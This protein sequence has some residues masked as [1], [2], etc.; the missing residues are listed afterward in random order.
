MAEKIVVQCGSCGS[1]FDVSGY[2]QGIAFKC[3]KCGG[4]VEYRPGLPP[5]K[6]PEDAERKGGVPATV[7]E[8][9]EIGEGSQTAETVMELSAGDGGEEE[10][11]EIGDSGEEEK[12][13]T[14]SRYTAMEAFKRSREGE[15]VKGVKKFGDFHVIQELGRGAMG[16]VYE[17][18]Q[19]PL[20]RRV[21]LKVMLPSFT[22]SPEAVERFLRESKSTAKLKHPNIVPVYGMGEQDGTYF[23][24]MGFIE[25][26]SLK[27]ALK[28]DVMP[29]KERAAILRDA[30]RALHYAHEQGV[31]HRD[32]KPANIMIDKDKKVL[33]ADFGIAKSEEQST[34]TASGQVL[35][36]PMYM[37]P[38]QAEGGS[39]HVDGR[40]DIYSLGATLY[41]SIT[42][43]RPY[44]G[45]DVRS[46][47]RNVIETEPVSPRKIDPKIPRDLE[48]VCLKA[49]E[50]P[51]NK[52]YETAGDM[53]ED[54]DHFI[55]GEPIKAKPIGPLARLGRKMRKNKLTTALILLV[56][57]LLAGGAGVTGYRILEKQKAARERQDRIEKG[58]KEAAAIFEKGRENPDK[59]LE[60]K[61]AY[62]RV[63]AIDTGNTAAKE[64]TEKCDLMIKDLNRLK[65]EA[66]VRQALREASAAFEKE[67]YEEAKKI[68]QQILLF[69]E[70]NDAAQVGIEKCD[71]QI[72]HLM[73]EKEKYAK[74]QK[75]KALAKAGEAA[76]REGAG[77]I[78]TAGGHFEEGEEK[79]GRMALKEALALLDGAAGKF[80]EAL[81]LY[82]GYRTA[83]H[84]RVGAN[85]AR[86][87]GAVLVKAYARAVGFLL[88]AKEA[89]A[90]EFF[91]ERWNAL[92]RKAVGT[93]TLTLRSN[94]A[95]AEVTVAV[96]E[97]DPAARKKPESLGTTPIEGRDMAMGN[98][99]LRLEKAGFEPVIYPLMVERN[100]AV[101]AEVRLLAK[102]AIP[103]GMVYVPGGVFRRG[104]AYAGFEKIPVKGFFM[105]VREVSHEEYFEFMQTIPDQ[106]ERMLRLPRKV[107]RDKTF[108]WWRLKT[109]KNFQK[110]KGRKLPCWGI[111]R[112]NAQAYAAW[113]GKRLPTVTEWEKAARGVD[114]RQWPWGNVFLE[115]RC[116]FFGRRPKLMVEPVDAYEQWRSPYGCVNMAGNVAEWTSTNGPQ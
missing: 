16:V 60:A 82:P 110:Q 1:S 56:M 35:G 4:R 79:A 83:R 103:E 114:G 24:A 23:Y 111:S 11:S 86:A 68:Y 10:E 48:T 95:G 52:R 49:M 108:V 94:P 39:S 98:Y 84:G 7:I 67:A 54:L 65:N 91:P 53:G 57:L 6:E 85:L 36:T 78:R 81:D 43:A 69:D 8:E 92:Y 62:E 33:I 70:G 25:G 31:I 5:S 17:A 9:Q 14:G 90:V 115:D 75:A 93:G 101:E 100:E 40:S 42:L 34:L 106:G 38:E 41:E 89:G 51:P 113:K 18:I 32:I 20:G 29:F 3:T 45:E 21:A 109:F 102:G 46:I 59:Y 55:Q 12:P 107:D 80:T 27:D 77:K 64:G 97:A 37:S 88:A 22:S 19:E 2:A 76:L 116:N 104:D 63:L 50:K 99:M 112:E 74:M 13:S 15:G 58:L 61:S 87:E 26:D 72:K 105:D 47:L 30:C 71:L 73:A 96:V 66:K 44:H 28:D